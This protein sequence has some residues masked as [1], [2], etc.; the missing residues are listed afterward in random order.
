LFGSGDRNHSPIAFLSN[1]AGNVG[2]LVWLDVHETA[3]DLDKSLE[4]AATDVGYQE[5]FA[6]AGDLFVD[7]SAHQA[8]M[9]RL[10]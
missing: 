7:G 5:R 8:F 2:E 6:S 1:V 9:T 10:G 4:W 3:A